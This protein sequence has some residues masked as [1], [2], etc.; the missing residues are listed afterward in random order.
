MVVT[1]DDD[2]GP[3]EGPTVT[4]RARCHCGLVSYAYRIPAR[5]LPLQAAVCSCDT[6]RRVTGQ[7]FAT[8]AVVPGDA[9][10]V[11]LEPAAVGYEGTRAG[12]EGDGSGSRSESRDGNR[13]E[14]AH[15]SSY[16][17]SPQAT[18]VFCPHCGASVVNFEDGEWEF[19]TGILSVVYRH[20]PRAEGGGREQDRGEE[21]GDGSVAAD[22]ADTQPRRRLLDRVALF[23]DDT[24]DGGGMIW[25]DGGLDGAAATMRQAHIP[26]H[27]G[28]RSTPLADVHGMTRWASA[29]LVGGQTA[30]REAAGGAAWGTQDRDNPAAGPIEAQ[31]LQEEEEDVLRASCHCGAFQCLMTR[32]MP[33]SPEPNAERGKWWLGSPL[34]SSTS[35]GCR[36]GEAG[37]GAEEKDQGQLPA[38][39]TLPQQQRQRYAGWLDACTSCRLVT[40]FEVVSWAHIP[41]VNYRQYYFSSSSSSSASFTTTPLDPSTHPALAHYTSSPG[42]WRDFCATCGAAVFY[43]RDDRVPQVWDICAGLLLPTKGPTDGKGG[44]RAEGWVDWRGIE[45]AEGAELDPEFVNGIQEGMERDGC[46]GKTS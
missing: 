42:V 25:L 23:A 16:A 11:A 1:H 3:K 30:D 18:R 33:D 24:V 9:V 41:A 38:G 35:P 12:R 43:R 37:A 17:S 28:H 19:A 44:A 15:L 27:G 40:G 4:L 36:G 2:V 26:I 46:L 32:P 39:Q 8:F 10:P 31:D 34:P 7:L 29:A 20:H 21:D 45:F 6:C 22:E 5:R 14:T 13:P